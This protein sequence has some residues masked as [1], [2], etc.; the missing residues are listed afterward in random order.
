MDLM[1]RVASLLKEKDISQA[2]FA[3][4]IDVSPQALSAWM[5]GINQPSVQVVARMCEELSVSPSWLI[6]G[7]EDVVHAQSLVD[8]DSVLIPLLD[9]QASCGNG[10]HTEHAALVKLIEVNRQ[11]ISRYCGQVNERALNIIGIY[12]DSMSPTLEDGDFAVVDRSVT[13]IY[14]DAMF[15]FQMSNDLFVK[16]FQRIGKELKVISDNRERYDPYILKPEDLDSSFKVL[17]RV[18]TTCTVRSA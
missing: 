11:W 8:T 3:R 9:V 10:F 15:A 17:G 12:G 1:K 16:R 2:S 5:S 13:R 6:T 18:V 14:T 4:K 7:R